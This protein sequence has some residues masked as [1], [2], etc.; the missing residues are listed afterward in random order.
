MWSA[1]LD[2]F[3]DSPSQTRV[4]RFLLENGFGVN[5]TGK[6]SCNNI[7]V[8]ATQVASKLHVDRRVVE[9]TARRILTSPFRDIFINMRATPDLSVIAENLSLSVITVIPQ[10]ASKPGVVEACIHTLS[11]HQI[12]LRQIF[13]TDPH[14]S[15]APR[16]VII[17]EGKIPAGVI[18]ELRDLPVVKKLI[19]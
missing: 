18:D 11:T 9:A 8:A 13:V 12:G 1:I 7:A 17:A 6:I 4:V 2:W 5:E 16:L 15:E 10:D 3:A 14:L 19:F